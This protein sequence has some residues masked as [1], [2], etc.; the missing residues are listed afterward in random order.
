MARVLLACLVVAGPWVACGNGEK[1]PS[2]ATTAARPARPAFRLV[3]LTDLN[4]YL[5]PCGCQSRPLGGIDKAAAQLK[6]S[7]KDGVPAMFVSAGALLF[8]TR[9]GG[10]HGA[11]AAGTEQGLA[12]Q[13]RAQAETLA[14][15]LARL[16][17]VAAVPGRPDLH[18]GVETVASLGARAKLSWLG[19]EI[20]GAGAA[21]A[22]LQASM[23]WKRDGVAVGVL[24]V[25]EP[26]GEA[27]L[28]PPADLLAAAQR[29]SDALRAQ[30]ADVVVAL[31]VSDARGARRVAGGLKGVD[32]A[33][34]GGLDSAETPPPERVGGTTLLR[35]GRD[36]HG[37][38]VVDVFRKATGAFVDVSPWTR[39]GERDALQRKAGELA[40][41]VQAWERDPAADKALVAEQ[42]AR[43][44]QLQEQLAALSGTAV[45][46]GNAFSAR[47]VELGPEIPDDPELSALLQAHDVR[48]NDAN[49][50]ALAGVAP[51]PVAKGEPGYV[52]S[53][54]CGDC[55][56]EAYA[57]WRGHEHGRAYATLEK[58]NK[59]YNLSCVDCHVTGYGKR[60]GAAVVQNS[61]LIDV[62]CESCHGPGGMHVEDQDID[63]A[64]NVSLAVAE[65]VCTACHNHEHSDKFVYATYR[66]KLIVPGHGKPAEK[67]EP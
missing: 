50:R 32:F 29:T 58:V 42:K 27:G 1:R 20:G 12:Q 24:G 26:G 2:A 40:S 34:A 53:A 11:T 33:I 6:A 19:A 15:A 43:L 41:R 28:E 67:N 64:K 48:V 10:E 52:G 36:G 14:D 35:A 38:L 3:A 25:L 21:K 44:A 66:A 51:L 65:P 22:G 49:K 7:G 47:F 16:G 31:I 39:K 23:L 57:W 30:G 37:L 18:R 45:A 8:G 59:Q 13:E 60:G 17:M 56:E 5:E 46:D 62:G 55:H 61:G 63:P 54:R 4:G 9:A